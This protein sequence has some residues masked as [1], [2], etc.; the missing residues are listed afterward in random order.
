MYDELVLCLIPMLMSLLVFHPL[1]GLKSRGSKGKT[2][3]PHNQRIAESEWSQPSA[4]P[5]PPKRT[6]T[7][8]TSEVAT[9]SDFP[10]LSSTQP[11]GDDPTSSHTTNTGDKERKLKEKSR[12]TSKGSSDAIVELKVDKTQQSIENKVPRFDKTQLASREPFISPEQDPSGCHR[13]ARREQ[14]PRFD[15]TQLASN[16]PVI[17]PGKDSSG[18]QQ[19]AKQDKAPRFDRT[20]L[21]SN[22]PVITPGKDSSG[23]HQEAKQDH[24]PRFDKTQL[25]S[26]EPLIKPG[27]DSAGRERQDEFP[28]FNKTQTASNEPVLPPGKDPIEWYWETKHSNTNVG[29]KQSKPNCGKKSTS[30]EDFRTVFDQY[31]EVN[32]DVSTACSTFYWI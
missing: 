21:A 29:K 32:P 16:E 9:K 23:C 10:A 8:G 27:K 6:A 31:N 19:G 25:A 26:N 4:L 14:A 17:T 20:Q 3:R 15:K 18:C 5:S 11:S 22:E 13:E 12:D 2:L 24:V 7:T 28:R 1:C 30:H